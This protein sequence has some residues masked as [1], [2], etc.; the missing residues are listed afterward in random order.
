M[1]THGMSAPMP[2]AQW[3]PVGGIGRL[4]LAVLSGR[5]RHNVVHLAP[6]PRVSMMSLAHAASIPT[7]GVG[8]MVP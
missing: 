2:I 3:C 5:P 4:V 7:S 8:C 6:P 1:V